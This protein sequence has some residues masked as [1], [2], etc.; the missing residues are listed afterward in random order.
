VKRT[1]K[2]DLDYKVFHTASK[3]VLQKN[4]DIY[5]FKQDGI[6]SFK[7][8]PIFPIIHAPL[9]LFSEK[10]AKLIWGI[11]SAIS[12]LVAYFL[13]IDLLSFYLPGLK[14]RY[15]PQ[16]LSILLIAQPLTNNAIQGNINAILFFLIVYAAW[17]A[18]RGKFFLPGLLASVAFSIKL[19]PGAIIFYFLVLKN[20]KSILSFILAT[21]IFFL[22][23]PV[24]FYG[25]DEIIP[26]F[27]NWKSV[28]SDTN[29]Y[30]FLKYTNQ[31]PL[32]IAHRFFS[33]HTSKFIHY[34]FNLFIITALISSLR[35]YK[36]LETLLVSFIL[37]LC[38]GPVIW[39]EYF[40]LLLPA[41][42]VINYYM[43]EKNCSLQ[44]KIL[45]VAKIIL[46]NLLVKFFVGKDLSVLFAKYGQHLL[47][48]LLTIL[49][50]ILIS[51]K[52][53]FK[54]SRN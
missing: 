24:L 30:P 22:I 51:K 36:Q 34:G 10:D 9:A 39:I 25:L 28:L 45:W 49:T 14:Q 4:F 26:L 2:K 16:F 53:D 6:F 23:I 19:I 50:L 41:Y 37:M 18:Q 44:L 52:Q 31:S 35:K 47:G 48:L 15:G 40:I 17:L 1:Y 54:L 38:F 13:L 43:F 27:Q 21:F 33:M 7:Y 46:T 42:L 32:I 5:N 11:L 3:R 12:F 29:H 20:Y 8:G